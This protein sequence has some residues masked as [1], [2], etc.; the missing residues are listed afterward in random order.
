M[1]TVGEI[2]RVARVYLGGKWKICDVDQQFCYHPTAVVTLNYTELLLSF[3]VMLVTAQ[4]ETPASTAER[5]AGRPQ[6]DPLAMH[7]LAGAVRLHRRR[8]DVARQN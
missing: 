1:E 6:P 3:S 7:R 4:I 5:A 2:V 8:E